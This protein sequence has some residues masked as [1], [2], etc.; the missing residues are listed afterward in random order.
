[1]LLYCCPVHSI[2]LR[3]EIPKFTLGMTESTLGPLVLSATEKESLQEVLSEWK[4]ILA[5]G[6]HA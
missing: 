5:N 4:S 2:C 3:R 1:M 6:Q